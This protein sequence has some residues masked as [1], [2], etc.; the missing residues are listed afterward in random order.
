MANPFLP[1]DP[2]AIPKLPAITEEPTRHVHSRE[3]E[4]YIK[5]LYMRLW[6]ISVS[7]A[8]YDRGGKKVSGMLETEQML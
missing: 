6:G 4:F 8:E 1:H 5:P 3:M 7:E 2:E